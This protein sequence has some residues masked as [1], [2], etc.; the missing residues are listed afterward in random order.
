[1]RGFGPEPGEVQHGSGE[2]SGEGLGDFGACWVVFSAWLRSI[3]QKK[4]V[5]KSVQLL[6]LPPTLIVFC[7]RPFLADFFFFGQRVSTLLGP[8]EQY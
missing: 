8:T 4:K 5:K 1:M 6:G 7:K 3:L 2:G